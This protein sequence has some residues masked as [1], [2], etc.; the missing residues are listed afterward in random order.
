[1]GLPFSRWWKVKDGARAVEE[2]FV[3]EGLAGPSSVEELI[4]KAV[5]WVDRY[6]VVCADVNGHGLTVVSLR[7]PRTA[8][9]LWGLGYAR[10]DDVLVL[11]VEVEGVAFLVHAHWHKRDREAL[12]SPRGFFLVRSKEELRG[13]VERVLREFYEYERR[14]LAPE[15]I[16]YLLMGRSYEWVTIFKDGMMLLSSSGEC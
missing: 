10:P 16:S 11:P 3:E 15:D 5:E 6:D 12:D 14:R 8:R 13:L 4:E 1:V 2:G 9:V 7:L